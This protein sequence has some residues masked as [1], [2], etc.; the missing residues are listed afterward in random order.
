MAG[1]PLA[2]LALLWPSQLSK[3]SFLGPVW[4]VLSVLPLLLPF[5]DSLNDCMSDDKLDGW[6]GVECWALL[7][8]EIRNNNNNNNNNSPV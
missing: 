4:S 7:S 1:V 3:D 5:S 8:M 6:N 2:L